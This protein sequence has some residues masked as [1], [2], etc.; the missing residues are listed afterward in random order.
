MKNIILIIAMIAALTVQNIFAQ[1]NSNQ[2]FQ[3][4]IKL[5]LDVKNALTKDNGDS[6]R[7][8]SKIFYKAVSDFPMEKFPAAQHK[9][10]MEYAEKLS[11]D[12]EHMK[13]TNEL[14]HQREHFTKLS[15]NL[16]NLLTKLKINAGELYYDFCPMANNGK[17]AFWISEEAKIN[18]PYMGKMMPRCGSVKDTIKAN[19]Q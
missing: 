14:E 8:T 10:W 18:N 7:A 15:I 17:G 11:Y 4:V 3:D 16:Y 13:Q 1:D 6:V 19:N 12:A 5:Y 9:I 2:S